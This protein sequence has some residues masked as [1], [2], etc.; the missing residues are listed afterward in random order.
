[1]QLSVTS[2]PDTTRIG[3]LLRLP[4]HLVGHSTV[5]RVLQGPLRGK[6][7][8][9]GSAVHSCWLGLYE[10]TKVSRFAELLSR[11]DVVFDLGANVGLYSLLAALKVGYVGRVI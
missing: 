2:I 3:R 4:L 8:I 6:R 7:W 5:V 10:V 11:G 1:M 9:A